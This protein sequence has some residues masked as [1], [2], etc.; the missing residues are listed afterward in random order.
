MKLQQTEEKLREL[1]VKGEE[2]SQTPGDTVEER[3]HGRGEKRSRGKESRY[4]GRS[5]SID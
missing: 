5:F 3:I 4:R 1:E 2:H